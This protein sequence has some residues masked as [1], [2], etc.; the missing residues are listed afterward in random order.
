MHIYMMYECVY[1]YIYTERERERERDT[2]LYIDTEPRGRTVADRGR[3]EERCKIPASIA[4]IAI[5]AIIA[6]IAIIA[7]IA[8]IYIYIYI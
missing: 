1:I 3:E 8:S 6:S 7:I 5:I 2:P 4:I